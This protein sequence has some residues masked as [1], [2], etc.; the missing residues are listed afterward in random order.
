M[1]TLL[2]ALRQYI[3]ISESGEQALT[4]VDCNAAL[5]TALLHL[6]G[7]IAQSGASIECRSLPMVES[8]EILIVQLFQNLIGNAIKYAREETPHVQVRAEESDGAWIFSV[9]D[10]G[11]GIEPQYAD[12]IFGVFKRLHGKKYSGTG[13]GLAICKAAV[14]RLGG[15]IWVESQPGVG[16][17][18]RF[19][20]PRRTA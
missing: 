9:Q 4:P 7:M 18:F 20:L 2:A 19:T 15:R 5:R 12:F 10:N 6:K 3:Y 11:I 1:A 14:D 8:I 16:S 17:T 13:I